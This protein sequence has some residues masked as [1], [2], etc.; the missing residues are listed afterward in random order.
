MLDNE[1]DGRMTGEPHGT[2]ADR[3]EGGRLRRLKGIAKKETEAVK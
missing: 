2:G 3:K 1:I